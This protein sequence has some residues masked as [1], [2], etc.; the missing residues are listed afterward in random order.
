MSE[1]QVVDGDLMGRPWS[2][3]VMAIGLAV[4][5]AAALMVANNAA[6]DPVWVSILTSL[7]AGLG[8][9]VM[10][11]GRDRFG[12]SVALLALATGA[13]LA[14][15]QWV[16]PYYADGTASWDTG[17]Q[18]ALTALGFA[19]GLVLAGLLALALLRRAPTLTVAATIGAGVSVLTAD[20]IL[21]R[22]VWPRVAVL[23]AAVAA[24]LLAWD[25]APKIEATFG[26]GP[27]AAR[28]VRAALSLATVVFAG[29]AIELWWTGDRSQ[30][31]PFPAVVVAVALLVIAFLA[32]VGVR[33]EIQQRETTL[34]E[35]RA[36]FREGRTGDFESQLA[37][38]DA[39]VG[40]L[41]SRPPP[42]LSFPNL[43]VDGQPESP[44]GTQ[45]AA[46]AEAPAA[47]GRVDAGDSAAVAPLPVG[48]LATP[49]ADREPLSVGPDTAE[50]PAVEFLADAEPALRWAEDLVEATPAPPPAA[51][52]APVQPGPDAPAAQAAATAQTAQPVRAARPEPTAEPARPAPVGAFSAWL[53]E[54]GPSV[55]TLDDLGAWLTRSRSRPDRLVAAV[56]TMSLDDFDTLPAD[57]GAAMTDAMGELL[58]T[59]DPEPALIT[60]VDGP[61]L[62]VA[63]DRIGPELVGT[64]NSTILTT[65]A[66]PVDTVHGPVAMDGV[67]ALVQVDST[68]TVDRLIDDAI[69]GLV[70]ARHHVELV[71]PA[72]AERR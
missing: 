53:G 70:R 43:Q 26:P 54:P 24:T 1:V 9:I 23:V 22:T 35:W 64:V 4:G 2:L 38:S 7:A 61:Y 56:E 32:L 60:H 49:G 62:M 41:I 46:G 17:E 34:A 15:V 20:T 30:G 71:D 57:V 25:Q 33:R 10:A 68:L 39:S 67:V 12:P 69:V 40:D 31:N 11:S 18:L 45:P 5:L 13:G 14:A 37:G 27:L 8:L 6:V 58:E 51:G 47:V 21:L 63:W 42:N 44:A 3:G 59:V 55:G 72:G 16:S 19:N 28:T 66:T 52:F 29:A 36:W 50:V 48:P 65:L